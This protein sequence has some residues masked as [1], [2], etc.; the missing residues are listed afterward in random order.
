MRRGNESEE[1]HNSA[2]EEHNRRQQK[3]VLVTVIHDSGHHQGPDDVAQGLAGAPQPQHQPPA[4]F[5]EPVAHDGH[6]TGPACGLHQAVQHHQADVG[7]LRVA[8]DPLQH[9]P[10]DEDDDG[11][12]DHPG[13]EHQPQ[14]LAVG[15]EAADVEAQGVSEKERR[16]HDAEE[17]FRL[18]VAP[19][20]ARG[21]LSGPG[22]ATQEAVCWRHGGHVD[23]DVV[24]IDVVVDA[25][26]WRPFVAEGAL[27][28]AQRFPDGVEEG[29]AEEREEEHCWMVCRPLL[30]LL[31]FIKL[32]SLSL[33][34]FLFC[35]VLEVLLVVVVVMRSYSSSSSSF[36]SI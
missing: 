19:H 34:L 3:S 15:N 13:A 10:E 36:I 20:E 16:V 8:A 29:V 17:L 26:A 27:D 32:L 28:V 21:A 2:S 9:G 24:V 35:F 30:H 1:N 25:V 6:Y 22:G 33:Y 4:A 12:E 11:G 31:C 14:V 7:R 18:I 23:V 5:A